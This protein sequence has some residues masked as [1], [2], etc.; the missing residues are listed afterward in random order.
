MLAAAGYYWSRGFGWIRS[1][2]AMGGGRY[3]YAQ[4]AAGHSAE[5]VSVS[6]RVRDLI[7]LEGAVTKRD[8][9]TG[10]IVYESRFHR[11]LYLPPRA[12][13]ETARLRVEDGLL[14]LEILNGEGSALAAP[15][16]VPP[17]P[18]RSLGVF[19]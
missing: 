3:V 4:A 7:Q 5:T 13:A 1:F 8:A 12:V 15:A 9:E 6:F 17:K 2:R 14:L 18:P 10:R 16:G 11:L 19:S